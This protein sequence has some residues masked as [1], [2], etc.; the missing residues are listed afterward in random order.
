MTPAESPTFQQSQTN[1]L[2]FYDALPLY[3]QV[4][5]VDDTIRYVEYV[6]EDNNEEEPT[7]Y[8]RT[9]ATFTLN[10]EYLGDAFVTLN[11]LTLAK[12]VDYSLSGYVLTISGSVI[13]GDIITIVYT[14]TSNQT[15]VSNSIEI[16]NP[17]VSGSTNGQGS[18]K[19][20]Y[21][22]STS[23]YEV[24]TDNQILDGSRIILILNGITLT[25]NIDYYLSTTNKKR[26][27]LNGN[28]MV[29]DIINVIYYPIANVINGITQNNNYINWYIPT[30][31][32][33][34]NGE[35]ALEY[36][37][38][39]SFSTYTVNSTV[40]YQR[41]VTSYTS[42]LSLSGDVGTNWYYRVKNIKNY[43]SICGDL[44]SS[45]GYSETVRVQ[46][47][48]NAINSY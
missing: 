13:E 25:Y 15:I 37:N 44:I 4:I 40:P 33:S 24:Y 32:Q 16:S 20:Y 31:P 5:I 10:S 19:V 36:S 29:G 8:T 26:I 21:N 7:L 46:I 2:S 41:G 1:D 22:T 39:N 14:R 18:N 48:S 28:I 3:Q 42:I 35:F 9:G 45:T 38:S 11:G 17:I 6:D 23:K 12:D 43:Q 30:P 27:I 47:Q 34:S